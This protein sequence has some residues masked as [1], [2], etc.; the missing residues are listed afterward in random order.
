MQLF[1]YSGMVMSSVSTCARDLVVS[2]TTSQVEYLKVYF[3][4][5]ISFFI[6]FSN[7]ESLQL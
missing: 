7:D 6:S 1:K 3:L 5:V 2:Y 4:R